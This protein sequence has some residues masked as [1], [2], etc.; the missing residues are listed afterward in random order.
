MRI[1]EDFLDDEASELG[2][3]DVRTGDKEES[4]YQ[5][6]FIFCT[7]NSVAPVKYSPREWKLVVDEFFEKFYRIFDRL[8]IIDDYYKDFDLY[9][10]WHEHEVKSG[11]DWNNKQDIY[12]QSD[13]IETD[14]GH[15]IVVAD[16]Y[17]D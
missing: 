10:G 11:V 7:A 12:K 13:I 14:N 16:R 4:A 3:E 5:Y 9:V 8:L 1:N 15:R 2:T 17:R 6:R